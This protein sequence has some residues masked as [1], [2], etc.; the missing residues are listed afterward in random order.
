MDRYAPSEMEIVD[1]FTH[2]IF[3]GSDRLTPREE[4]ILDALCQVDKNAANCSHGELPGAEEEVHCLDAIAD[5]RQAMFDCPAL[6]RLDGHASVGETV[7]NKQ[8]FHR[9]A[10]RLTHDA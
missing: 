6:K 2:V 5:Q 7:L 8:N 3:C 4:S 1:A 10:D 9:S